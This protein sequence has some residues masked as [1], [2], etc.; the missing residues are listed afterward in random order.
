MAGD[1]MAG[2]LMAGDL[3]A[4]VANRKPG[5]GSC[6][7]L[8]NADTILRMDGAWEDW[9][10]CMA[11][12]YGTWLPGDPRGF[13]TRHHREHL[14]GDYK[15]PPPTG[16]YEQ[17]HHNARQLLRQ[18]QIVLEA[19]DVRLFTCR[20]FGHALLF[21]QIELRELCLSRVHLH[22]LARFR[23]PPAESKLW[24]YAPRKI[25]G[26]PQS[27]PSPDGGLSDGGLSDGTG[28][29]QQAR[30]RE[31]PGFGLGAIDLD[32]LRNPLP[33]WVIGKAKSWTARQL[34]TQGHLPDQPGSVFAEKGKV[35]PIRDVAHGDTVAGYIRDHAEKENAAVWS[36]HVL[37]V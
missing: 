20:V 3:M 11:N 28:D 30:Q 18:S 21:H 32:D 36:L 23:P 14:E 34:K 4:V 24:Q 7:A 2:D 5:N 26:A 15:Q 33:R 31:L 19:F 10:H 29:N 27:P 25:H 6:R 9:Y 8:D 37:D 22:L 12:A 13:R 35:V 16:R 17:R 1:L